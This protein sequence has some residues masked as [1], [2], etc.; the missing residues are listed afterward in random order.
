[1]LAASIP[2]ADYELPA[3]LEQ[4]RGIL[5][6]PSWGLSIKTLLPPGVGCMLHMKMHTH[7][8]G[9]AKQFFTSLAQG[10][11]LTAADPVYQVRERFLHERKELYHTAVV[12]RAALIVRAWNACRGIRPLPQG[13]WAGTSAQFPTVE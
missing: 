11:E 8:P 7:D 3:F 1:M 13:R 5:S 6:S 2:M 10:V 12:E 9:L 4:H